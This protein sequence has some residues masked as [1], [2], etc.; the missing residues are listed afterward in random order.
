VVAFDG[1]VVD[2]RVQLRGLHAD[3]WVDAEIDLVTSDKDGEREGQQYV[4]WD[5]A[6]AS[7]HG[8]RTVRSRQQFSADT[9]T[10]RVVVITFDPVDDIPFWDAQGSAGLLPERDE[11]VLGHHV[12]RWPHVQT[13]PVQHRRLPSSCTRQ[14][15]LSP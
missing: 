2:I 9:C 8:K 5:A 3:G 12:R 1:C 15:C 14:C 10:A 4:E 7:S 6:S 11:L 13:D